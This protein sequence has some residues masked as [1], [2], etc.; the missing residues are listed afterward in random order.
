MYQRTS[1]YPCRFGGQSDS[2]TCRGRCGP[3]CRRRRMPRRPGYLAGLLLFILITQPVPA[4]EKS[5]APAK[6]VWTN[7]LF[8]L[9]DAPQ[10]PTTTAN[11][12]SLA[13]TSTPTARS[14][15]I[16]DAVAIFLQQNLQ[17]LAARYDIDTA[18][19]EKLTARLRPN[20]QLSLST[21]GVPLS[22]TGP[23]VKE[24]TFDYGVSQTFELGGKRE[25]RIAAADAN[26][27]LARG[28]FQAV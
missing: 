6:Q 7:N 1:N 20:P 4:Q 12:T 17:L 11:P 21:S 9:P 25:K 5:P 3:H 26:A 23:F 10:T 16:S 8:V 2:T 19:A 14:L 24:Q 28:Q 15:T 18:E 22:F 13:S 27:E